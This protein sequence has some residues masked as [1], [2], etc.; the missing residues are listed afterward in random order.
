MNHNTPTKKTLNSILFAA[1]LVSSPAASIGNSQVR[2]GNPAPP[3]AKIPPVAQRANTMAY[4]LGK[5]SGTVWWDTTKIQLSLLTKPAPMSLVNRCVG[6]S[7]SAGEGNLPQTKTVGNAQSFN[8]SSVGNIAKCDFEIDG[9]PIGAPLVVGY[10][11]NQNMFK[12][13]VVTYNQSS[14]FAIP[15]GTC[16]KSVPSNDPNAGVTTCGDRAFNVNIQLTPISS[17]QPMAF[18]PSGVRLPDSVVARKIQMVEPG[19]IS[20]AIWWDTTQ[21]QL[22]YP[23]NPVINDCVSGVKVAAEVKE[24]KA[25]QQLQFP[26]MVPVGAFNVISPAQQFGTVAVCFY[27]ITGVPVTTDVTIL[28]TLNPNIFL[29]PTGG[30]LPHSTGQVNVHIPGGSCAAP[31]RQPSNAKQLGVPVTYCGNG[32]YY[33]NYSLT[34]TSIN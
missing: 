22:P 13:L 3:Q 33:V 14:A 16:T 4:T 6:L 20:G 26:S 19:T 34:P 24:A 5:I 18:S 23:N 27:Q 2:N 11:A 7:V 1:L 12:T 17:A 10:H 25:G 29:P 21:L 8:Y 15:G 32:A 30:N 9:V 28:V 31:P